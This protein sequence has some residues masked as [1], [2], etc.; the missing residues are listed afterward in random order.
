MVYDNI[1][2]VLEPKPKDVFQLTVFGC[3]RQWDRGN[4]MFE[5][6]NV[7][8]EIIAENFNLAFG[9]YVWKITAK[10]Y[11]YSFE[12]GTS[13]ADDKASDNMYLG[14]QGEKGNH[15]VHDDEPLLKMFLRR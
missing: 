9:H 12:T 11:R 10:R 8:D 3:D 6:T 15:Q 2:K 14:F 7:E 5:I 1:I 13:Q 4:R